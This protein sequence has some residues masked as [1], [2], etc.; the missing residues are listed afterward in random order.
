MPGLP[1][2]CYPLVFH[3]SFKAI[4]VKFTTQCSSALTAPTVSQSEIVKIVQTSAGA[5]TAAVKA[6]R[7]VFAAWLRYRSVLKA[8]A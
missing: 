5:S 4:L 7:A 3:S 2:F 8:V 6:A 1:T